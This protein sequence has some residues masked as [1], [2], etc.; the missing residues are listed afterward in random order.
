MVLTNSSAMPDDIG[1]HLLNPSAELE[2]PR[3]SIAVLL[4]KIIESRGATAA[5]ATY[6]ELKSEHADDYDFGEHQLYR[7]GYL[8]MSRDR[9]E[10]AIAVLGLNVEA[11]P[12]SWN[13]HDSYGEALLENGETEEAIVHYRRSVELNPGHQ[14]G[15]T[16]LKRLG[17]DVR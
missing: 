9:I 4:N 17:V 14:A 1:F 2:T 16:A 10:D 8:Y 13:A 3:P 6:A 5:V 12:D 15:I 7:L 11:Y